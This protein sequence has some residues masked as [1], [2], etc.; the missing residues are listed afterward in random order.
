[1]QTMGHYG[2][3]INHTFAQSPESNGI[4][5]RFFRIIEE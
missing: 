5:E 3:D 2:I 4:I 1:M